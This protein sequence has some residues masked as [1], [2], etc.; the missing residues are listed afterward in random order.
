MEE[1]R[2]YNQNTIEEK[3]KHAIILAKLKKRMVNI[4][5]SRYAKE[6]P[7]YDAYYLGNVINGKVLDFDFLLVLE[8]KIKTIEKLSR[9]KSIS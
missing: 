5:M 7:E 4:G 8:E 3:K 1:K 2:K 9:T 6:F